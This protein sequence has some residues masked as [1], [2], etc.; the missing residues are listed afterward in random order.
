[1]ARLKSAKE[2]WSFINDIVKD[3]KRYRTSSLKTELRYNQVR[4]YMHYQDKFPNLKT[5]RSLLITEEMH[6]KTM[7]I[8]LPADPS[9][10]MA[11]VVDSG[12]SRCFSSMPHVKPSKPCFN[13]AKGTCRFV[14]RC[15]FVH[16][17]NVRN[18]PNNSVEINASNMDEILV[19]L[20]G[21]LGLN[22]KH[23]ISIV[24]PSNNNNTPTQPLPT[25]YYVSP[26]QGPTHS[27]LA[28]ITVRFYNQTH[29]P[30]GSPLSMPAQQL[31]NL[32]GAMGPAAV[33]EQATA[34]PT[35]F[36]ARTLH[37]P[38]TGAWN[39]DTGASSHLNSLVTSLSDIFNTCITGDLYPVTT[40]SLIPQALLVS[41]HMWHQQLGHPGST[42]RTV[43]SL[44]ASRHWPIHQL[45]VK[46]A[47]LYEDLSETVYMHQHLGF[48]ESTHPDYKKYAIEI[49]EKAHMVSCNPSRTP[50]D[51]ESKLGVH[52]DMIRLFLSESCRFSPPHL[53]ALKRILRYVQGTVNYTLQLFSSSTTDLSAKRQP[54]LSRSS[55]EAEYHCVANA[56]AKTCWLWNL[57]RN[58]DQ[59]QRT[60]HIEIDIHFVRDLVVVGQVRVLHV[61]SRY[62]FADIYTKGLP[63]T[64]FEEFR[65]SLSV[66]CPFAPTAKKC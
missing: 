18:T 47:F 15:Q 1:V 6:L 44:A 10:P 14:E 13:Y 37:D 20:L 45:D 65:S 43:L 26:T 19:K 36:T 35:A 29:Y 42:I 50:V 28:S 5:A 49:L 22:S 30:F 58:P 4:G 57:L 46:N 40:P 24:G 27:Y 61:S 8:A 63:S 59:H 33:P 48:Q 60:K 2:A 62:Q 66:R 32:P 17:P 7:D 54:T 51:I 16:D 41:Q 56:V 23:D 25:V 55:A 34:L 38:A 21:R 31:V 9:S 3:N 64:L 52:G 39:M 11:L 12:N 53:S